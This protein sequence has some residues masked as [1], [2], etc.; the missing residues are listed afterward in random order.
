MYVCTI[1][2]NIKLYVMYKLVRYMLYVYNGTPTTYLHFQDTTVL[3]TR[4]PVKREA[5]LRGERG[6]AA[7]TV[8]GRGR[9]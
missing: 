3:F 8:H 1:V 9:P 5:G 7:H 4:S 2:Y 6:A